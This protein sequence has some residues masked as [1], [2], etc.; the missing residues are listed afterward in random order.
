MEKIFLRN[1]NGEKLAGVL[2]KS[3]KT[4]KLV[5][6]C[7][8]RLCTKDQ[9]FY[10]D[11]SHELSK[12]G[13]NCFRFDFAGNGESQGKFEDSTTTKEIEDI[14]AIT[15]FFKQKGYKIHCLIGHSK[16][17]VDVL[18]HQAKYHTA[19][20]I[21]SISCLVNQEFETTKKYSVKQIKELNQNGYFAIQ[22]NKKKFK[23]SKQYFYDRLKYRDISKELKKI[24]VPVLVIHGTKDE[25]THPK[26]AKTMIKTLN[27]KSQLITINGADHFYSKL[28]HKNKLLN[29]ISNWLKNNEKNE[30]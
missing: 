27:K 30:F 12:R 15:S 24:L 8:G 4:D 18:L 28:G 9:Y 5:I 6:I 22:F 16:G 20:I 1:S 25:D 14:K 29:T 2:E 3:S 26:N 7:H 23:I 11:L 21:I 17:A 10:P 13:F 19:K